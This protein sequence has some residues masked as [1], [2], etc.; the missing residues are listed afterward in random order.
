MPD[1]ALRSDSWY[2]GNMA[3]RIGAKEKISITLDRDLARRI[4]KLA[5]QGRVSEWLNDAALLRLQAEMIDALIRKH[6]V[7]VSPAL[8]AEIE[9]QWPKG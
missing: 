1:F 3:S 6:K 5:G 4:R 9:S 2:D 7:D 8:M